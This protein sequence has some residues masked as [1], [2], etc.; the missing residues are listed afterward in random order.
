[1]FSTSFQKKGTNP[2]QTPRFKG[3]CHHCGKW[4]HKKENCR[5][6][7]K[8]TKEQQEQAD[9]EKSEEKP[10]KYLQHGR[11]YNCNKMWH[12]TKD[13]PEK[14]IKGFQWGSSG[15]FTMMFVIGG[16]SPVEEDPEQQNSEVKSEA[17]AE[18]QNS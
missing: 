10:K 4:G 3:R 15:G 17:G 16:K 14:Q 18:E 9:K 8:L 11:C 1:M 2:R 6:W 13:C 5:E 7:L 12:L